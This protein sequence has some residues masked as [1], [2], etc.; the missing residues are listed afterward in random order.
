MRFYVIGDRETVLG[1]RMTGVDGT[2]ASDRESA[3][4]A[5]HAASADRQTGVILITGTLAALMR[6]EM[7]TRM[8]KAGWPLILEIPDAS[9]PS[10]DRPD[11]ADIVR[12]AIGV[13]L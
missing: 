1:F 9:G 10:P 11:V 8:Y 3:M 13:N 7:N 12:R 2:I 6:E 5:L 4:A